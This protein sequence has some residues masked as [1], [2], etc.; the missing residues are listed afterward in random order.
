MR[1]IQKD[2]LPRTPWVSVHEEEAYPSQINAIAHV[3]GMFNGRAS[4][5]PTA[6]LLIQQKGFTLCGVLSQLFL[7]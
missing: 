1:P 4:R 3:V 5:S 6:A 2:R 7:S